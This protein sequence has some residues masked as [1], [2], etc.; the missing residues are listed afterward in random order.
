MEELNTARH[1]L[2][3][4]KNWGMSHCIAITQSKVHFNCKP[5]WCTKFSMTLWFHYGTYP[6]W[7]LLFGKNFA[8][9]ITWDKTVLLEANSALVDKKQNCRMEKIKCMYMWMHNKSIYLLLLLNSSSIFLAKINQTCP[10][11]SLSYIISTF[12]FRIVECNKMTIST[13]A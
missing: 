2:F 4:I 7:R 12:I 13:Y 5:W 6:T 3:F 1:S 10:L 11:L 9:P 8:S